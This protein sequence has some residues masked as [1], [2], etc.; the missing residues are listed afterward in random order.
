M[1]CPKCYVR[2][3]VIDS[4]ESGMGTRRRHGCPK[5][6]ERFTTKEVLADTSSELKLPLEYREVGKSGD[7]RTVFVLLVPSKDVPNA[8]KLLKLLE[9]G[10]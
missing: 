8:K 9:L 3:K 6:E 2:T 1:R 10:N 5:C 7:G 4:R